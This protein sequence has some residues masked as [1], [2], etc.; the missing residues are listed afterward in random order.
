MDI[1]QEENI[2]F[3]TRVL[4]FYFNLHNQNVKD[5]EA[6][7]L[8]TYTVIKILNMIHQTKDEEEKENSLQLLRDKQELQ[9]MLSRAPKLMQKYMT[10]I[11][12]DDGEDYLTKNFID[13]LNYFNNNESTI[14]RKCPEKDTKDKY[15]TLSYIDKNKYLFFNKDTSLCL[16]FITKYDCTNEWNYPFNIMNTRDRLF[17]PKQNTESNVETMMAKDTTV[18]I[19]HCDVFKC[20]FV[21][22]KYKDADNNK[23]LI[24]M[25]DEQR[26]KKELLR[27]FRTYLDGRAIY[28][29]MNNLRE[30]TFSQIYIPTLDIRSTWKLYEDDDDDDDNGDM[31]RNKNNND[32]PLLQIPIKVKNR[33]SNVYMHL[34]FTYAKKKTLIYSTDAIR[35]YDSRCFNAK[36][37]TCKPISPCCRCQAF[38]ASRETY[39]EDSLVINKPFLF[40]I[41]DKRNLVAKIGVYSGR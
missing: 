41:L 36:C 40:L 14:N 33:F 9:E 6:D 35:N 32:N 7:I 24:A 11:Y 3:N 18:G 38:S 1:I 39:N 17:Y 19:H 16:K 2:N 29:C 10:E 20:L 21:C 22:L 26:E 23:M 30:R 8:D 13:K 34:P 25:P 37:V 28:A 15:N 5:N 31:G 12:I 27:N 4:N